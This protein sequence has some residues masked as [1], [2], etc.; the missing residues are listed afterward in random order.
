MSE[1]TPAVLELLKLTDILIDGK[2]VLKEKSLMLKFRGS[3][4]QRIL[5][6]PASLAQG[7]AVPL[8]E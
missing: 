7:K 6:V 8:D 5:S 2:F 4:N 1:K 3:R